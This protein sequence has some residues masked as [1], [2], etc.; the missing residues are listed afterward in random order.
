M[1]KADIRKLSFE[2][3]WIYLFTKSIFQKFES[4]YF[5]TNTYFGGQM[6]FMLTTHVNKG[7]RVI[8][9]KGMYTHII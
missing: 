3:Y 9:N 2:N 7:T 6:T 1:S 8:G 5:A 4:S